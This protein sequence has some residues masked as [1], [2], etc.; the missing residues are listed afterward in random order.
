MHYTA[1]CKEF[2][3]LSVF[4]VNQKVKEF[5]PGAYHELNY[6]LEYIALHRM[7]HRE[8]KTSNNKLLDW[9]KKVIEIR[10]TAMKMQKNE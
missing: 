5:Q 2:W 6:K 1:P 8:P 9:E 10:V 7:D 3:N 4:Q